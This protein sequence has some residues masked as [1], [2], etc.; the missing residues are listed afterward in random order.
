MKYVIVLMKECYTSLEYDREI[1]SSKTLY[2]HWF[3]ASRENLLVNPDH[4]VI[5]RLNMGVHAH[6]V[7]GTAGNEDGDIHDPLMQ[8]REAHPP[9]KASRHVSFRTQSFPSGQPFARAHFNTSRCPPLAAAEQ[10]AEPPH[11]HPCSR[12]H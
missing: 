10:A 9:A 6:E 7:N 4:R 5:A 11:R 12:T 3:V 1:N 2:Q 8:A